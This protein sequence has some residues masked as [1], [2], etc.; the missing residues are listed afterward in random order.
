MGTGS[1]PKYLQHGHC[2]TSCY[3]HSPKILQTEVV[4]QF[5]DLQLA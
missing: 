4:L 2:T 1:V 3:G 5:S